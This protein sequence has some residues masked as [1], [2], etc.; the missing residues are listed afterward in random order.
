MS[1]AAKRVALKDD[2]YVDWDADGMQFR[3][4]YQGLLLAETNKG[5]LL[6][7]RATH[8]HGIRKQFHHQLKRLWEISPYLVAREECCLAGAEM[9]LKARPAIGDHA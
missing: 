8:K 1:V 2:P 3:L 7:A 9:C 6:N 5:E 4:T